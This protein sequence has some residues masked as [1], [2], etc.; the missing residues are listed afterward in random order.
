MYIVY[1]VPLLAEGKTTRG[2]EGLMR[3]VPVQIWLHIGSHDV[4]HPA[5][6]AAVW[7][8]TLLDRDSRLHSKMGPS[9]VNFSLFRAQ[10]VLDQPRHLTLLHRLP[11]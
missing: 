1:M 11:F 9:L 6:V 8:I 10:S 3:T 2:R 5:R 7:S 4:F